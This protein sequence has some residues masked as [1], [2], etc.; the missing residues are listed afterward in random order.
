[1]AMGIDESG[2]CRGTRGVEDI[3]RIGGGV[4]H[5]T[6]GDD[7]TVFHIDITVLDRRDIRR[8]DA[9]VDNTHK[10]HLL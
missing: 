5:V 3:A 10:I 9:R 1:M 4:G 8:Y 7:T 2:I 6:D